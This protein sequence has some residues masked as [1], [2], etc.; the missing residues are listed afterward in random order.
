MTRASSVN[1]FPQRTYTP[2]TSVYMNIMML[3]LTR[4]EIQIS[5]DGGDVRGRETPVRN[6]RE[7]AMS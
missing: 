3:S 5:P 1:G 4:S 2:V 7:Q 6:S